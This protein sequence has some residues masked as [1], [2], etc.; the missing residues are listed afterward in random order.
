MVLS[1]SDFLKHSRTFHST[2]LNILKRSTIFKNVL[3]NSMSTFELHKHSKKMISGIL[4]FL[5]WPRIFWNILRCSLTL[6]HP[7]PTKSTVDLKDFIFA[8]TPDSHEMQDVGRPTHPPQFEERRLR[9]FRLQTRQLVRQ[10]ETSLFEKY[11]L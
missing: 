8:F 6:F 5:E 4:G 2:H 9:L 7:S 1:V 10:R 3:K 11:T